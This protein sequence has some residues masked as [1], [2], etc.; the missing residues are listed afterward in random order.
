VTVA[1]YMLPHQKVSSNWGQVYCK[2]ESFDEEAS[3]S[4]KPADGAANA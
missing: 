1:N 3:A 4:R 2:V